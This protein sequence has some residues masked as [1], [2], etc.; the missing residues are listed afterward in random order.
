MW[1]LWFSF[2]NL[3]SEEGCGGNPTKHGEVS[4]H[5]DLLPIYLP[6]WESQQIPEILYVFEKT[7]SYYVTASYKSI[8]QRHI[9]YHL[10]HGSQ[11]HKDSNS[12][13]DNIIYNRYG[14]MT[15][16]TTTSITSLHY[17]HTIHQNHMCK[18]YMLVSYS[19]CQGASRSSM[20]PSGVA[21]FHPQITASKAFPAL[22][23]DHRSTQWMG[24]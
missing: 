20:L 12:W 19:Y 1:Y 5:S 16:M 22:S 13:Y 9:P 2:E 4:T 24:Y 14:D 3:G 18:Q 15:K 11:L 21:H 23:G 8:R 10:M 17:M 7:P 6:H